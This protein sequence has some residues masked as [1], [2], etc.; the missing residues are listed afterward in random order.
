[1]TFPVACAQ[2]ASIPFDIRANLAKADELI[3]DAARQGARLVL[4]PELFATGYTYDQRLTHHAEPIGGALTQWQQRRSRRLG[5]WIGAGIV[6]E[7]AGK[8]FDT[9]LLTGPAGEI[10]I[11]RKQ[12]PAFFEKLYFHSGADVGIFD[13]ALGRV[14]VMICWDMM[15][16]KLCRALAGK[17]DLLLICSAWPDLRCGNVP[18][19]GVRDWMSR[20][21]GKRPRKL[22]KQFQ[23]PVAYCNMAGDFHTRV[24]GLGLTY[25][26]TFCGNSSITD[27]HTTR[28]GVEEQLLIADVQLHTGRRRHA[29]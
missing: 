27:G 14:G 3:R 9:F 5:V 23:V 29:A 13:T 16:A 22:S 11:Y 19:F 25:R 21:P 2:M 6:E 10:H 12:Y 7:A 4:L 8:V 28:L 15:Q 24:P 18:L 26:T 1:M 20:Q 17:I